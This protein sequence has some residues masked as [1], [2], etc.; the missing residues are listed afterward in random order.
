MYVK[1]ILGDHVGEI[2][3]QTMDVPASNPIREIEYALNQ[4][5]RAND[6]ALANP[7]PRHRPTMAIPEPVEYAAAAPQE[8][9]PTIFDFLKMEMDLLNPDD[10]APEEMVIPSEDVIGG[11][12]VEKRRIYAL[13]EKYRRAFVSAQAE[14][15]LAPSHRQ[16]E[17]ACRIARLSY[18]YATITSFMFLTVRE[19]ADIWD[20]R[21]IGI[22]SG[23]KVVAY[24]RRPDLSSL[25]DL[26]RGGPQ[27]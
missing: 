22:R 10:Y 26:L 15:Q 24:E 1:I 7:E 8:T 9:E 25:G 16:G 6:G 23:W 13:G 21:Q 3:S 27:I 11:L 17:I 2:D 19:S 20:N 14:L 18:H 4:F 5:L 12:S